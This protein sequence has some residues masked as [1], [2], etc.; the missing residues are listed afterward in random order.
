MI[1]PNEV[2]DRRYALR[3]DAARRWRQH[4]AQIA[5]T[6]DR[7]T[8]QGPLA[9]ASPEQRERYLLR[10]TVKAAIGVRRPGLERAIGTLDLDGIAPSP[11]A[12]EAGKPVARIVELLDGRRIGDGFATGF[13]VA[14]PLLMTNW[15]V[16]ERPGDAQGA[17]AHLNYQQNEQGLLNP[18]VVYELDPAAF[19]YSNEALDIALVGLRAAAVAGSV[20]AP[21]SRFGQVRLIPTR[22]KILAGQPISIIQHPEGRPKQWAVRMNRLVREPEAADIYLEYTTD[23]LPGSSGSPAFNKDWEL[24]AVHHSGVPRMQGDDI[25][26]LD[27]GIWK[28]GIP[29]NAIDWVANEGARVSKVVEH[30]REL[31]LADPAQQA[32]LRALLDSSTDPVGNLMS[33]EMT[34]DPILTTAAIPVATADGRGISIVVHGTANFYLGGAGPAAPPAAV[35]APPVSTTVGVEKKIRF[36]PDYAGRPGFDAEHLPG[37]TVAHPKGPSD[38]VMKRD[39]AELVLPYHH[40]SLAMHKSRRFCLWAASNIDYDESKRRKTREEWGT[41]AWKLD[42]RIAGDKQ[43]EGAELYDPAKKFDQGHIV[44]RDDVAWGSTAREEEFGN[45]DSFHYTNCTPQHEEFNR[46]VFQYKGLWGELENHVAKQ[47]GFLEDRLIVF[48]GPVLADDDPPHDFGLGADIPIPIAF[49][50]VIVTVEDADAN[51]RLRAYAFL[52]SQQQAID[53]FGWENRF[54]AGKF[55]EYQVA[56]AEITTLTGVKFPQNVLAADAQGADPD[57]SRRRPLRS[58]E[59]VR[60]R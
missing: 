26:L 28:P 52:L 35:V 43:I 24:V 9:A 18:G 31:Q 57:E 12:L 8:R 29:D 20:E 16:F 54:R 22:G 41:D 14:G 40:Y 32:R 27:G 34:G 11:E 42:P 3:K 59:D 25:L 44:R 45:S 4:A 19:F 58:L 38:K 53:E 39:G 15:H 7:V 6:T 51:P 2:H 33:N 36:D 10:E 49:W 37:F 46:A 56:L 23:T 5:A 17:G 55:A 60:L 30:L 50:K 48:A 21:L 47:A 13:L 1:K